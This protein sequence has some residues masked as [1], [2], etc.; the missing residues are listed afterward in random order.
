MN[1]VVNRNACKT[2]FLANE[3]KKKKITYRQLFSFFFIL[4]VKPDNVPLGKYRMFMH[5][6][7]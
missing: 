2:M 6:H 4:V 3:I 5:W 7:A 1:H